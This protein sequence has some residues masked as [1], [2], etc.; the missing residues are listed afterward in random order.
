MENCKPSSTPMSAFTK[1]SSSGTSSM[2]N[3]SLYRSIVG[4]LQYATITRP[5]I[6]YSVN[7][8]CQYMHKPQL[9]H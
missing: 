5:D 2:D 3:S 1:L 7:K 9:H 4:A 6:T 8:V